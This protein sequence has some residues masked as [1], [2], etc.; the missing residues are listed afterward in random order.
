[1]AA[2]HPFSLAEVLPEPRRD[3]TI[4]SSYPLALYYNL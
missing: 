1:M 4:F 3:D 2:I